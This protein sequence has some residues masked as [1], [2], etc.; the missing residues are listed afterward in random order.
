M[1]LKFILV[2]L[3]IIIPLITRMEVQGDR[4]KLQ[5]GNQIIVSNHIGIL[6]GLLVYYF[7]DRDDIIMLLAEK[8]QD[9]W[10][11][12]TL[13]GQVDAIFVDRYN[14]DFSAIRTVLRRLQN[15]GVL[16]VAPEGTRSPDGSLR[17]GRFGVSYLA[18]KTGLPILPV[19]VTGTEDWM[20]K[21]KLL[22]LKRVPVGV[23]IG[24]QFT[25]PPAR[26]SE[27]R[28]MLKEY[29]D[30]IMCQIAALLPEDKRGVYAQHPR[31]KELLNV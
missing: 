4:E 19:A 1:L 10:I 28:E 27:R 11:T 13:A 29:T 24:D 12:R 8:H 31:V 16:I 15:G 7:V 17:E 3:N 2:L 9:R 18:T 6:E 30:E 14:A 25:L 26:G 21:S 20:V 22:R 23:R 5:R